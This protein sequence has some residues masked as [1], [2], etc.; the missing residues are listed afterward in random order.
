VASG[1]KVDVFAGETRPFLQ[2][3]R[4]TVWELQQDNIPATLITGVFGMNVKGLPFTDDD[5]GFLWAVGIVAA[6][7]AVT[8]WTLRRLGVLRR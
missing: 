2:G 1:K 5:T 3:A 7:S 8:I 4:L 6:A